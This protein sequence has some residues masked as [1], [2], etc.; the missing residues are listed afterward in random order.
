MG[1]HRLARTFHTRKACLEK[2]W[3]GHFWATE[4]GTERFVPMSERLENELENY[5]YEVLFSRPDDFIFHND[6]GEPLSSRYWH[7]HIVIAFEKMGI[8]IKSRN[9]KPH[10]FRHGFITRLKQQGVQYDVVRDVAGHEQERT[11]AGYTHF[12]PSFL[13]EKFRGSTGQD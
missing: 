7:R 13:V 2:S 1:R 12:Q 6:M 5:S 3:N 11:T 9:V 10:S 4:M 8:D